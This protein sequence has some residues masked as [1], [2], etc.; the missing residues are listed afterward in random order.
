MRN[1]LSPVMRAEAKGTGYGAWMLSMRHVDIDID[2]LRCFRSVAEHGGFTAASQ[3]LGL[4]QPA[5][6][7]KIQRLEQRVGKRVFDRNSRGLTVTPDGQKLLLYA[8]HLLELNDQMVRRLNAPPVRNRFRIAIADEFE[9]PFLAQ[10]LARFASDHPD[11][12]IE[13]DTG[14]YGTARR[15]PEQERFDVVIAPR[16]QDDANATLICTEQ[17]VWA[18]AIGWRLART[19]DGKLLPIDVVMHRPGTLLHERTATLLRLGGIPHEVKYTSNRTLG[20]IAAVE[21]GVGT[22]LLSR[23]MLLPSLRRLDGLPDPG[24]VRLVA[25]WSDRSRHLADLLVQFIRRNLPASV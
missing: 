25:Y 23:S 7:L 11:L 12:Q 22:A 21:L 16:G 3:A 14:N 24:E 9:P 17:L 15:E 8:G 5:V 18:A 1:E 19:H 4:T 2:L 10:L 20:V 13:A 6:S